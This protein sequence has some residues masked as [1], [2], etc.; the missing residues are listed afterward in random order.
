MST[1]NDP[2]DPSMDVIMYE[3]PAVN[4]WVTMSTHYQYHRIIHYSINRME[5]DPFVVDSDGDV[6][7]AE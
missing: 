4:F 6:E 7:M 1:A 5:E 2:N 3:E